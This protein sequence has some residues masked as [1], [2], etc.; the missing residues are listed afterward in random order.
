MYEKA[1][2]FMED[3]LKAFGAEPFPEIV[4]MPGSG[5]SFLS[6]KNEV[7]IIIGSETNVDTVPVADWLVVA[8]K[9]LLHNLGSDVVPLLLAPES[10]ADDA[11]LRVAEDLHYVVDLAAIYQC[12]LQNPVEAYCIYDEA[13]ELKDEAS[14]HPIAVALGLSHPRGLFSMGFNKEE[15]EPVFEES[16]FFKPVIVQKR[17]DLSLLVSL[18]NAWQKHMKSGVRIVN[19]EGVLRFEKA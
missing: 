14:L 17:P 13:I 5:I 15:H 18:Q 11:S 8:G 4:Q 19:E 7:A 9:V 3:H 10:K 16:D 1:K 6:D 12:Y 2:A